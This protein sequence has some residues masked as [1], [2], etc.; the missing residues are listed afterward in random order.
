MVEV[1]QEWMSREH[2]RSNDPATSHL[3]AASVKV[4]AKTLAAAILRELQRSGPGTFSEVARRLALGEQQ[5]WKRI[6]DLKRAELIEP[7]G[8]LRQG[9]SGRYQ[10]VWKAKQREEI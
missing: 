7:T 8:E 3:A 5:V 10:T 9:S 6:S 4:S 2:A 1:T